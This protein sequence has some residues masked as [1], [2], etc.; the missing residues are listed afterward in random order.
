MAGPRVGWSARLAESATRV[1]AAL[2][3]HA[4][5]AAPPGP[6]P[7]DRYE[8]V[9]VDA[10]KIFIGRDDEVM[11][12]YMRRAGCWEPEEGR[13]LLSL[14]HP[15]TRFLD[16]GANVGY[17]SVLIGRAAPGVVVD[18]VEPDPDNVAALRFN[19]WANGVAAR[20]WPVA[21]DDRDRFLALSG[22]EHNRGDLRSGRVSPDG[23]RP[24]PNM[25]ATAPA[26]GAASG[27]AQ[28]GPAWLVPAASGDALFAGRSFDLVKIDVQG[29]EYEVLL[30]LDA[31]LRRTPGV[32]IVTEFFPAPLRVTGRDPLD[33]LDHLRTLGYQFRV[34]LG[35]DLVTM[36]DAQIVEVCDTGGVTGQVN[37]LLER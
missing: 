25:I 12:P 15:G 13:L 2:G 18:A 29:W 33:V 14:T 8:L 31:V 36:D 16:V 27:D 17:F 1:T 34:L 23:D 26:G 21:L 10:G 5:T 4:E 24:S 28:K 19:L 20:V 37:L 9:D 3:H 32:R 11:R 6:L 7:A 22:D 35:D 30:G